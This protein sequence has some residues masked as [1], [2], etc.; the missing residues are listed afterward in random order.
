[1]ETNMSDT[2]IEY[3]NPNIIKRAIDATREGFVCI[4]DVVAT[5]LDICGRKVENLT[6]RYLPP[7]AAKIVNYIIGALPVAAFWVFTIITPFYLSLPIVTL[8]TLTLLAK[9]HTS[10][11]AAIN[12]ENG[13]GIGLTLAAVDMLKHLKRAQIHPAITVAFIALEVIF[14][15]L[16]FAKAF[17]LMRAES[18]LN[19]RYK[20]QPVRGCQLPD[21][22]F[23]TNKPIIF[24]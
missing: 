2:S 1:M 19:E 17:R 22:Y 7:T 23:Q 4:Y 6:N 15:G 24:S 12:I 5:G 18:K 20:E 8:Y 21:N 11:K 3:K 13:T 9:K 10:V 14:A 16:S